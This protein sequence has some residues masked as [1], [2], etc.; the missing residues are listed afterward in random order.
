MLSWEKRMANSI[1]WTAET[2]TVA[3]KQTVATGLFKPAQTDGKAL[4]VGADPTNS[5]ETLTAS[6]EQA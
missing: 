5:G 6:K 2:L 3:S 4:T 1:K